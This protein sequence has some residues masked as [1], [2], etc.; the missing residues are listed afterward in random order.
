MPKKTGICI[1]IGGRCSKAL[2]KEL[3]TVEATNFVCEECGRELKE[4]KAVPIGPNPKPIIII[5]AAVLS[6]VAAFF[7]IRYWLSRDVAITPSSVEVVEK[8]LHASKDDMQKDNSH[9]E[10]TTIY[11]QQAL[12]PDSESNIV[13]PSDESIQGAHETEI[14][15]KVDVA[16]VPLY[17]Y[18]GDMQNDKP[19]GN[20]TMIFISEGVVP[21][22]KDN[23]VARPGEYAQGKWVNG[24]VNLVTLY[25]KDGN[26]VIITHK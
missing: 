23:I 13:A 10:D 19:H 15:K 6:I 2:G 20:G 18:E 22:S 4:K 11:N 1:N 24:E 16:E 5:V 3:Q 25:Q 17:T 9:E 8:V 21:G 7:G 12:A 14:V 26:R